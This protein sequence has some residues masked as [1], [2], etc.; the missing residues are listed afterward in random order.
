MRHQDNYKSQ[1]QRVIKR[2]DWY[3]LI[4]IEPILRSE[5]YRHFKNNLKS[6]ITSI[7]PEF[8][9]TEWYRFLDQSFITLNLLRAERSNTELL[10]FAHLN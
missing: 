7:D 8:P 3:R 1:L 9:M 5:T 10:K 6:G 4:L 2:S